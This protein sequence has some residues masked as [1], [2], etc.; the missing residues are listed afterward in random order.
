MWRGFATTI[1]TPPEV[2]L[3]CLHEWNFGDTVS[4]YQHVVDRC[5]LL[6]NRMVL[7]LKGVS[8]QAIDTGTSLVYVPDSVADDFYAQVCTVSHPV[9]MLIVNFPS[10]TGFPQSHP[11]WTEYD[12]P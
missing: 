10:D 11:V 3:G 7:Q 8:P 1:L 12:P 9:R 6:L 5:E 4:N 2:L